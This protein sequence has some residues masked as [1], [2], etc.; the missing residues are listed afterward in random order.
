MLKT[1]LV[2]LDGSMRAERILPYV[3][4]IARHYDSRV[5]FLRVEEEPVLLERDEVVDFEKCHADYI[6]RRK[7]GESYLSERRDEFQKAGITAD[8]CIAYGPVVKAILKKGDE[9]DT[10]LIALASHGLSASTRMSYGSVAA[11]LLQSVARPILIFR[12]A[13]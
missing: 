1:I 7:Q 10:S 11:G 8:V 4:D 9:I 13:D 5:V 6:T 2:P 12:S 3:M